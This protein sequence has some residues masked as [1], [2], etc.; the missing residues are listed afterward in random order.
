MEPE[1]SL[2]CSQELSTGLYPEPD[3]SNPILYKIHF[4][5]AH[6]PMLGLPS[7]L[8]PSGFPTNILCLLRVENKHTENPDG[9]HL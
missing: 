4:N 9:L 5:I 1:G 8:F 2:L 7:G 3:Q 6:P